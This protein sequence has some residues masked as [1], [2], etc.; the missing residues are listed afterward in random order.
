MS[1]E[2]YIPNKGAQDAF[3]AAGIDPD[4]VSKRGITRHGY[5]QFV[6]SKAERR[7]RDE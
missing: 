6:E 3:R 4:Y 2:K 7:L 5:L 1:D